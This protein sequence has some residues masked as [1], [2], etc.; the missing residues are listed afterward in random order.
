[1]GEKAKEALKLQWCLDQRGR[2]SAHYE[3]MWEIPSK[4][5][6]RSQKRLWER[7]ALQFYSQ[8][9]ERD[10]MIEIDALP[11]H[12]AKTPILLIVFNR[13]DATQRVFDAIRLAQPKRLF[14]A[15]DGPRPDRP[16]DPEKCV[17]ARDIVK[18]VD[19]DCEVKTLFQDKNL[20]CG[21]GPV[22]AINWFFENVEEGIILEDDCLPHPDF[23]RFCE[24]LLDYYRENERIM[25]IS[26]DNFQYGRKRGNA[27]Y[28]FSTYTH[29]W[30]WA[31]WRRAWKCYDFYCT[32]EEHRKHAWDAQWEISAR[33]RGGL[34]IL[35]NV[36]LVSNIGFGPDATHTTALARYANLPTQ[37]LSFPLVHPK[38]L[39]PNK[40]ADRYTYY[41]HF[42]GETSII[43][44]MVRRHVVDPI[45]GAIARK[46]IGAMRSILA[47]LYAYI[48]SRW[49]RRGTL[50]LLRDYKGCKNYS[51][52]MDVFN[53]FG[54]VKR[55]VPKTVTFFSYEFYVPDCPSF[56]WQLKEIFLDEYY[57]FDSPPH[58]QGITIYDCGANIGTSCLYFR[59]LFPNARI[60]AF[61]AD[62][63]IAKVCE[64]NLGKN[65]ISGIQLI[66]KAVWV[67]NDGVEFVTDGA[68]GGSIYGDNRHKTRVASVRLKHYL[69]KE[70]QVDML[71]M[72]IEGAEV[73]VILDCQGCLSKVRNLFVEYHSWKDQE[74][75][76]DE[77]LSV[78]SANGFRYFMKPVSDRKQ[79][80]RNKGKELNMD[81]QLNI[82]AYRG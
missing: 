60:I 76:L 32:S 18:R 54:G 29:N 27:S 62:P 21:L 38:R 40:A 70:E 52:F 28:Y 53:K 55:Y 73:D 37:S 80:F 75:R 15:A 61:E 4:W 81:L 45:R 9:I 44:G 59:L 6:E 10:G 5:H 31:T 56:I 2:R 42:C 48:L 49:Y 1:M 14:V 66:P 22:T 82:F 39:L 17:A 65:R 3:L 51:E 30:G 57:R 13:P 63:E 64:A 68:D 12:R 33:N 25:H 46:A 67:A 50:R 24:E 74:Q 16:G 72:D 58:R 77:I 69:E 43:T 35:P 34:A 41:T 20:G 47:P 36:N 79:P 7:K 78:L 23:F 26:G 11:H 19:W 71:K 8:F